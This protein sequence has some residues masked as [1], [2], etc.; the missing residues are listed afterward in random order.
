MR[1]WHNKEKVLP[2]VYTFLLLLLSGTALMAQDTSYNT[3]RA[4]ADNNDEWYNQGWAWFVIIIVAIILIMAFSRKNK[5]MVHRNP[6]R[7]KGKR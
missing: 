1:K 6:S 4:A 2:R 5:N 3:R 7:D